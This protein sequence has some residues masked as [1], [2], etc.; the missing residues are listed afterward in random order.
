MLFS[1]SDNLERAKQTGEKKK[2]G[3]GNTNV[4]FQVKSNINVRIEP[5]L[6]IKALS[7]QS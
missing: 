1:G 5:G 3:F 7:I 6:R 4:K 2:D